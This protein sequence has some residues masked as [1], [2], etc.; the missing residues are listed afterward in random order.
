MTHDVAMKLSA[1]LVAAGFPHSVHVGIYDGMNP[2]VQ[3][4]VDLHFPR[5]Y[6]GGIAAGVAQL[7]EIGRAHELV[8]HTS[9][10][11]DGL[12]YS[13]AAQLERLP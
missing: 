5:S 1:D 3:S 12:T 6:R 9:M 10:L 8:L 11:G 2:A 7:E 13:T 4:R